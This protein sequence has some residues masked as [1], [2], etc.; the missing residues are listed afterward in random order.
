M[1]E[2]IR[3]LTPPNGGDDMLHA[4][5]MGGALG[6]HGAIS[7]PM[8]VAAAVPAPLPPLPQ[9]LPVLLP[10][11]VA[12]KRP[13]PPVPPF[14]NFPVASQPAKRLKLGEGPWRHAGLM[15]EFGGVKQYLRMVKGEIYW[16]PS[17]S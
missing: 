6:C 10:F 12:P 7:Q 16:P 4:L 9:P 14:H 5:I 11:P 17:S 1:D 8:T 3:P 13:L 15:N 2:D